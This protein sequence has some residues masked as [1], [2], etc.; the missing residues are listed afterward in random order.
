LEDS[1]F[2]KQAFAKSLKERIFCFPDGTGYNS[3]D[4][5]LIGKIH[6]FYKG[7]LYELATMLRPDT[8]FEEVNHEQARVVHAR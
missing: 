3:R 5:S 4:K 8:P 1:L 2:N 6:C 7:K